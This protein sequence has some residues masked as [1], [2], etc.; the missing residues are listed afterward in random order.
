MSAKITAILRLGLEPEQQVSWCLFTGASTELS[1]VT[2]QYGSLEEAAQKLANRS[3]VVF[4]PAS[5]VVLHRVELPIRNRQRLRAAVPFSLEDSLISSVGETH[6][7]IAESRRGAEKGT[8]VAA[9]AHSKIQ[10]WVD[11]LKKAAF[12]VE[13]LIPEQFGFS[14][15]EEAAI[16]L[17][18]EQ[19]YLSHPGSEWVWVTRPENL[20][21]ISALLSAD[22]QKVALYQVGGVVT[23]LWG[24][25][26]VQQES[27][28]VES[29]LPII[30]STWL[31]N[32]NRGVNLLQ[33][34]YR[35]GERWRQLLQYWEGTASLI[36]AVILLV[37]ISAW[38]QVI[39]RRMDHNQYRTKIESLYRQTF[40]AAKRVVNPRLQMERKLSALNQAE[41][42]GQAT[43][44]QALKNISYILKNKILNKK[45][46]GKLR[47]LNF[48][49]GGF[50][51]SLEVKSLQ[52]L[53]QLKENLSHETGYGVEIVNASSVEGKI[54]GRIKITLPDFQLGNINK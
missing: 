36:V 47:L 14:G 4:V 34:R 43:P 52:H 48:K 11:L 28:T 42:P 46:G 30:A 10:H 29:L 2:T 53:D 32:D 33:G 12:R 25:I 9:V 22:E 7:A 19:V 27:S 35:P 49:N 20:E 17:E 44:L 23:P 8:L 41:Q 16:W 1:A 45:E 21:E 5:E 51:L 38:V 50:D 54:E 13:C 3:V 24:E 18:Q 15:E 37:T 6:F 40:P 39:E 31:L 26:E